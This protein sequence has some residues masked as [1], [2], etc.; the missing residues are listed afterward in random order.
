MRQTDD[1]LM[2]QVQAVAAMIARIA[3]LR[4][5]GSVDEARLVLEQAYGV[6]LAGRAGLV[7]RLDAATAASLLG[8]P[9]RILCLARLL[10]E[11]GRL[12]GD[13]TLHA[14]AIELTREALRR[15]PE[16]GP[17]KS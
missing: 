4:I 5:E 6:L 11:E 13:A 15:D 1:Y 8:S 2:R 14:R 10:E 9:E 17:E 3:G 16:N 7:R 12:E